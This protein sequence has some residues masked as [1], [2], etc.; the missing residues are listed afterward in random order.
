MPRHIDNLVVGRLWQDINC[1]RTYVPL[2]ARPRTYP[3]CLV[4][5]WATGAPTS[6]QLGALEH[7]VQNFDDYMKRMKLAFFSKFNDDV[8]PL[9]QLSPASDEEQ[10]WSQLEW[11]GTIFVDESGVVIV[12]VRNRWDEWGHDTNFSFLDD[13]LELE[14]GC[15]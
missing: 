7:F 9:F 2:V 1:W 13:N 12:S 8:V 3:Y 10:A 4:E 11:P 6:A 14:V 15:A 5:I